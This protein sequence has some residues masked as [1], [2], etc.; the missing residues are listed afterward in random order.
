MPPPDFATWIQSARDHL[1]LTA[2]I[3]GLVYAVVMLAALPKP[4]PGRRIVGILFGG[5]M[6]FTIGLLFLAKATASG[7]FGTDAAN[8]LM[9]PADTTSPEAA[10]AYLAFAAIAFLALA[11]NI[12]LRAAAVLGPAIYMVAPLLAT[13]PTMDGLIAHAVELTIVT[14]GAVLLLLQA[15]V[16]RPARPSD[17]ATPILAPEPSA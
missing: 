11:R 8:W 1:P 7:A 12:G 9:V 4:H 15:A 13:T 14:I 10:Y 2:L 6:F 3:A 17:H 16:D 5:Y